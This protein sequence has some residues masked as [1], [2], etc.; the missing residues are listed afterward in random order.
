MAIW[1]FSALVSI[2][3]KKFHYLEKEAKAKLWVRAEQDLWNYFSSGRGYVYLLGFQCG[4]CCVNLIK[5]SSFCVVTELKTWSALWNLL[6]SLLLFNDMWRFFF[7]NLFMVR[8]SIACLFTILAAEKNGYYEQ[9]PFLDAKIVN[10]GQTLHF[11]VTLGIQVEV[12]SFL[13]IWIFV[14]ILT[15]LIFF[16]MLF[17]CDWF[18]I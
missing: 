5:L 15:C 11:Y 6:D 2:F 7:F 8:A 13:T 12:S 9:I 17:T 18:Q 1:R 10:F 14:N 4:R 16:I 3:I